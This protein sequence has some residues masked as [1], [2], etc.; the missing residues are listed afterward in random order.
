MELIRCNAGIYGT[1][2]KTDH[3]DFFVGILKKNYYISNLYKEHL[4][5]R[6]HN[7]QEFPQPRSHSFSITIG[8]EMPWGTCKFRTFT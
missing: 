5:I 1:S 4:A 6:S 3:A 8:T 7:N 2:R